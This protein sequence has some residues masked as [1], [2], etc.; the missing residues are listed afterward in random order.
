MSS[1]SKSSSLLGGLLKL[2][3]PAGK[4]PGTGLLQLEK[5]MSKMGGGAGGG[6]TSG[7]SPDPNNVFDLIKDEIPSI[8][9]GYATN[10]D[11][12]PSIVFVAC[13]GILTLGHLYIFVKNF[14][15]GHK[16]WASAGLALY[17][18]FRVI[19]FGLRTKWAHEQANVNLGIATTVFTLVPAV[20]V[21]MM[22]MLFGHRIFTWR[23][24]ETGDAPWFNSFMLSNYI[25]VIPFVVVGIVAQAIPNIYFLTPH[26]VKIFSQLTQAMTI[27]E[28]MFPF[29]GLVL[30]FTAYAFPTG[31]LDRKFGCFHKKGSKQNLPATFS[32]SWIKHVGVNY[33]VKRG[34]QVQF[35][36]DE[37]EAKAV[38]VIASN[39]TPAGGHCSH[40]HGG[41]N[42]DGP[43]IKTNVG[44][45]LITSI[46]LSIGPTFQ[47]ASTFKQIPSMDGLTHNN[48]S[49]LFKSWLMYMWMGAG[50]VIVNILF[51]VMRIDLRFYIPDR[52]V[53]RSEKDLGSRPTISYDISGDAGPYGQYSGN[54]D[55][56]AALFAINSTTKLNQP[57]K[58]TEIA[59]DS[60]D[61][62]P[63][64]NEPQYGY[65]YSNYNFK[66]ESNVNINNHNDFPN[67]YDEKNVI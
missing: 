24:P 48:N 57:V 9:G 52:P 46:I 33:F 26:Q 3:T 7:G 61:S 17:C 67:G 58:I 15:R 50:E 21:S 53:K 66:A 56:S 27:L 25:S 6:T 40:H 39:E 43:S 28:A 4:V 42:S 16:F 60:V 55:S 54:I 29:S 36:E 59:N 47:A 63:D 65:R 18:F 8:F 1:E 22:N 11:L 20:Y 37:P 35:Y 19:G 38:R 2:V 49:W 44:L 30:I 10:S 5:S 51:L 23:H 14:R 41:I 62:L 64:T 32:P 31:T 34:S 45:I 12:A 13:F